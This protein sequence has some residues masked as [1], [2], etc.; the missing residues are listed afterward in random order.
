MEGALDTFYHYVDLTNEQISL[1]MK[2]RVTRATWANWA[3]GIR[4]NL[5]RPAFR[6]AWAE[7]ARLAP[8]SFD[9][10]RRLEA[11]DFRA[12]PRSWRKEPP[13][14]PTVRPG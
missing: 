12:D 8:D 14:R 2:G 9:D 11:S 4:S 10:L 1:R 6:A 5:S 3:D 13:A 7:I